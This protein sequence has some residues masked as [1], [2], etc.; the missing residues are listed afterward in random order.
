VKDHRDRRSTED[1]PDGDE[2]GHIDVL[3]SRREQGESAEAEQ[4]H[5]PVTGTPLPPKRPAST[6]SKP[7]A[8]Y[9][10]STQIGS[11]GPFRK[12]ATS[13]PAANNIPIARTISATCR[14]CAL[15][16]WLAVRPPDRW[17]DDISGGS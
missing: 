14:D 12:S 11:V 2:T 15:Q 3:Q 1:R 13:T 8:V 9:N 5:G 4:R 17:S 10:C 6:Y 7:T 16:V